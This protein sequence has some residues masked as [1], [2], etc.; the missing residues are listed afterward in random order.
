MSKVIEAVENN[1]EVKEV[2]ESK[3]KCFITKTCN[4]IK[5][6]PVATT[7]VVVTAVGAVFGVCKFVGENKAIDSMTLIDDVIDNAL[8]EAV[9]VTES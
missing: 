4:T 3:F 9:E 7:I 2:K 8:D 1:E 6:H 5:E